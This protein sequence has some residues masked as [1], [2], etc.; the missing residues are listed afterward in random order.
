MVEFLVAYAAFLAAHVLPRL[1]GARDRAVARFGR[2]AYMAGYGVLSVALLVWL[3]SAALRAPVLEIWA[4]SRPLMLAPHV[5]MPLACLLLAGAAARPNPG[6][7]AFVG[8]P[9]PETAAG[10][11]ALVRHPV[12]WA[13]GLWALGH[14]AANGDVAAVALFGGFAVFAF[15]G[16]AA[17]DR[18]AARAG[19]PPTARGPFAARLAR[20][21]SP[22]LAVEIAAGLALWALLLALHG[23]V[24][25][26]DPRGWL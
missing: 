20:A 14:V 4:P 5:L 26:V 22:R 15:A 7:V 25:G 19:I 1:T 12:L 23:P 17:L 13:F 24:I 6:S 2:G 10:L 11:P 21:W 8:G 18:R 9:A 16:M 3:V